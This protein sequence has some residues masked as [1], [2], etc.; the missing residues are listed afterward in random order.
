MDAQVDEHQ[1]VLATLDDKLIPQAQNADLKS[2]L[3][4]VR[5]KVAS[6]LKMAQDVQASL[7]H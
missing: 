3:E 2:L 6:H 4:K 5:A 7:S 1:K